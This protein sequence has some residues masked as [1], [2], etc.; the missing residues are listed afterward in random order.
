MLLCTAASPAV[1]H[2][3]LAGASPP[4]NASVQPP[5][6][7]LLLSFSEPADPAF[8]SAAVV[9]QRGQTVAGPGQLSADGRRLTAPLPS[10]PNG[11]YT[12]RW[13]VLSAV[14]GHT[15]AGMYTFAVGVAA[16]AAEP[17]G[18]VTPP[19][20]QVAFRWLTYMAAL[21]LAGTA[22]YVYFIV[23]PAL[24]VAEPHLAVSVDEIAAIAVRRIVVPAAIL[25]IAGLALGF[26]AQ[27][28]ALFD[29]P[30]GR[31]LTGGPLRA[32][33]FGTRAGWSMLLQAAMAAVLLIPSTR[34]GRVFRMAAVLW[35]AVVGSLALVASTPGS[36]TA[37]QHSLHVAALLLVGTVYG[38]ISVMAA[39]ILPLVPDLRLPQAVWA[40]PAAGALMLVGITL[41]AHAGGAGWP[42]LAADWL[43]LIAAAA[44]VGGLAGLLA[45]LRTA[46]AGLRPGVTRALLPRFSKVAGLSLLTLVVTGTYAAW[47]HV[48]AW[49][50]LIVT[51]YGRS[52]LVK[53]LFVVPWIAL[54]AFNHFVMRPRLARSA[55]RPPLRRFVRL[56]GGEVALAGAVVA[57]VAVLSITPP[58]RV[59]MP[60]QAESGIVL[61]GIT[62]ALRVRLSVVPARV[63]WNTYEVAVDRGGSP[64]GLDGRVQLRLMKLDEDAAPAVVV[65]SSSA[66][67]VYRGDGPHLSLPGWWRADVVLR[68]RGQ[69][70]QIVELPLRLAGAPDAPGTPEAAGILAGAL[71]R[72]QAV[73][74]WREIEQITDGRGNVVRTRFAFA[75]PDRLH[76]QTS[77][78]TEAIFIGSTRYTREGGSWRTDALASPLTLDGPQAEFLRDPRRPTLGRLDRCGNE[79][80][81]VVFWEAPA[82][83]ARFAGWIGERS[84]LIY[85]ML[86]IAP[87]HYMTA[88]TF[89]ID[90]PVTIEPPP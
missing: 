72:S 90:A 82:G 86:M 52:L 16:P 56:L 46:P 78:G 15:T 83:T 57:A 70:D 34:R 10:L 31:L 24:A 26:V 84:R 85:R 45:T 18:D 7:E 47:L 37:G 2:G 29:V 3:V 60:A 41:N 63:G 58:A 44:W 67:G 32:M 50:G 73:S 61:A 20:L 17:A 87:Q 76:Y 80:C 48:P 4:P 71:R 5:L 25:L 38:L 35:A 1:A 13:R 74:S 23:R 51:P 81:R 64:V 36:V 53:L 68:Q 62:D 19:P 40:A 54:G 77:S 43:H 55:D 39:I 65:L 14:D 28:Q 79:P 27:A 11:I 42:A 49:S 59:T 75:A 88:T 6:D 22:F 21:L 69:L 33:L 8:T 89:D 30:L 66:G 9:D 12:V